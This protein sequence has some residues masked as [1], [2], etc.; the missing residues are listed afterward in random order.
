MLANNKRRL[1]WSFRLGVAYDIL[2]NDD[3][4]DV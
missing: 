1:P 3:D 2:V 4:D